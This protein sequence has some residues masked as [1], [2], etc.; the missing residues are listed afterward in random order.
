[1]TAFE[2]EIDPDFEREI[3]RCYH[4]TM[5]QRELDGERTGGASSGRRLFGTLRSAGLEIVAAG[6]SDWVVFADRHGRYPQ[7]EANF[8]HRLVDTIERVVGPELP[9]PD[10]QSWAR[11]RRSQIERGELVYIAHQLDLLAAKP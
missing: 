1:M 10:V 2:P 4:E 3:E 8:L 11:Q 9:G 6:G 5:Q 7:Q